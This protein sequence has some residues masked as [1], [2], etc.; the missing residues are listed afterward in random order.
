MAILARVFQ[1]I[2]KE[3]KGPATSLFPRPF[4]LSTDTLFPYPSGN[5]SL[6]P[7]IKILNDYDN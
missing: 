4:H 1:E 6:L 3:A 2:M 5:N 7:P